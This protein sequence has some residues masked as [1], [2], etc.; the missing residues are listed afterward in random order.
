MLGTYIGGVTVTGSLVAYGKLDGEFWGFYDVCFCLIFSF[1]NWINLHFLSFILLQYISTNS[2]SLTGRLSSAAL[3]LPGRH[4][5]N[6]S[7]MAANIGLMAA[8][9][10]TPSLATGDIAYR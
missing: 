7:L 6:A 8:F 4:Y 3:L 2:P 5:L 1:P 10:T 9:Y